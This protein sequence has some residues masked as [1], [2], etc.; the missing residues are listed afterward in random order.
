[1]NTKHTHTHNDSILL[2][3]ALYFQYFAEFSP[4]KVLCVCVFMVSKAYKKCVEIRD[5][6]DKKF[7]G[8]DL[9]RAIG[10]VVGIDKRVMAQYKEALLLFNLI[11]KTGLDDYE[12]VE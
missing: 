1:M 8:R 11:R 10:M 3:T 5:M 12:R 9:E 2:L 7:H 6:L 4:F